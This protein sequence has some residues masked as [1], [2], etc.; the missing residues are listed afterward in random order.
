[1]IRNINRF[2]AEQ[3][4]SIAAG[5]FSVAMVL[6]IMTLRYMNYFL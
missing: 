5:A 2:W 6:I 4:Q 1:M 3:S